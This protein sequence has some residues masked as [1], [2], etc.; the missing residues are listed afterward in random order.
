LEY[1]KQN[2]INSIDKS[3]NKRF[4]LDFDCQANSICP[5][6]FP[7]AFRFFDSALISPFCV[8]PGPTGCARQAYCFIFSFVFYQVHNFQGIINE[9]RFLFFGLKSRHYMEMTLLI[10]AAA[11][12]WYQSEILMVNEV[13]SACGHLCCGL[14]LCK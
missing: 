7:H 14:F 6:H 1:S 13:Q 3:P 10:K 11:S 9:L 2:K 12:D 4:S 5:W 8:Y